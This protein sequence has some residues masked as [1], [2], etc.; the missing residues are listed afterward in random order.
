VSNKPNLDGYVDVAQRLRLALLA[1]PNL[2]IVESAPE[3]RHVGDRAFLEVNVTVWRNEDDAQP[4]NAHAWEPF[5]G[6]TPFTRDSEMMNAATSALGRA[7]GY[8][9]FG[10]DRGISTAD[11]IRHRQDTPDAPYRPVEAPVSADPVSDGPLPTPRQLDTLH[12]I[13]RERGQDFAQWTPATAKQASE[14]IEAV[15]ALPKVRG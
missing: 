2:R 9:G 5:P 13:C 15:K 1:H 11:E 14:Y 6:R 3:I 8:M 12:A 10:I 7:L 4:V